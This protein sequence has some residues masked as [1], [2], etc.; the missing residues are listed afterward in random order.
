MA[1]FCTKRQCLSKAPS[2]KAPLSNEFA[3][4]VRSAGTLTAAVSKRGSRQIA[5]GRIRGG[6]NAPRSELSKT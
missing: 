4:I 6:K 2:Q 3:Q 5:R 1:L